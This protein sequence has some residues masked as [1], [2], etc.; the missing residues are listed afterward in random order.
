PTND[1]IA[2]LADVLAVGDTILDGGNSYYKDSVRR[3]E[4][5]RA[6]GLHF[7]DVGISGGVWGLAGGYSL[8]VGGD[9]AIV[10]RHQPLFEAL[11]PAPDRG[12]GHVGPAGAGHYVKMVLNAIEYGLMQ[13][14]AEG[15]DPLNAKRE[16]A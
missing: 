7:I 2:A 9:Q 11:A 16:F 12:W 10:E 4:D 14:Y 15:F 3:A 1:A 6:A 8:M 13:A 5:L